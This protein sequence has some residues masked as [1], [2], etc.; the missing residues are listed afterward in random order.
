MNSTKQCSVKDSLRASSQQQTVQSAK[1]DAMG[2][3]L[4]EM[5][6]LLLQ[7]ELRMEVQTAALNTQMNSMNAA[8]R[9]QTKDWRIHDWYQGVLRTHQWYSSDTE[10]E[11]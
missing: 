2:C 10:N 8:L 3:R 4:D 9:G 1:V 11:T 7:R 5:R 6:K